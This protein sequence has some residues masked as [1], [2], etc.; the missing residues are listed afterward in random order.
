MPIKTQNIWSTLETSGLLTV[1]VMQAAIGENKQITTAE[2]EAAIFSVL[3]IQKHTTSTRR[4]LHTLITDPQ[5]FK[6]QYIFDDLLLAKKL[7]A[8]DTISHLCPTPTG[9]VILKENGESWY[10]QIEDELNTRRLASAVVGLPIPRLLKVYEEESDYPYMLQEYIYG[11]SF[12]ELTNKELKIPQILIWDLGYLAIQAIQ[13]LHKHGIVHWD[14]ANK[15]DH[16]IVD[17]TGRV[18]YIDFGISSYSK[19]LQSDH[20]IED[21]LSVVNSIITI[22]MHHGHEQ[23]AE[24]LD[25]IQL[26][27]RF[28]TGIVQYFKERSSFATDMRATGIPPEYFNIDLKLPKRNPFLDEYSAESRR[29]MYKVTQALVQY[30]GTDVMRTN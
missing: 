17:T 8:N 25:S 15:A 16:I 1:P 23:I 24:E 2:V 3:Q 21:L 13:Y 7:T 22:F 18:R 11:C 27:K 29:E 26:K 14:L 12:A 19:N 4:L 28:K 5:E 10:P 6:T 20:G 30:A 9:I